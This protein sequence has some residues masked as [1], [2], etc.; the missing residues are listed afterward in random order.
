M[1]WPAEH[2]TP[3]HIS[4]L[5]NVSLETR[6]PFWA[7]FHDSDPAGG[8]H[9]VPSFIILKISLDLKQES[10]AVTGYEYCGAHNP[11]ATHLWI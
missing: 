9:Q 4:E 2:D 5:Q 10:H 3:L 7:H 11:A 1:M 6:F 8:S